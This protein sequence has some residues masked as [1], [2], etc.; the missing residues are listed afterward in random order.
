MHSISSVLNTVEK[1]DYTFKIDLQDTYFHVLIHPDGRKYLCLP[2]KTSYTRSEHCLSGIYSFGAHS[3]SYLHRQGISVT[4]YL[5]NLLIHHPDHQVLL[6]HQ[7]H[8][9]NTLNMVG[10][11]LNEAKS[12]LEPVQ[13]IQFL[14]H[15]LCLDHGRASLPIS[16]ARE[17]IARACQISS[18]TVLSY[19]EVF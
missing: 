12:K 6:R 1:G 11:Q 15:R 5:D 16:K 17:I 18:Q 13:D 8:L 2:S 4:P 7:S 9:T 10:L 19:R 14:G 3:G